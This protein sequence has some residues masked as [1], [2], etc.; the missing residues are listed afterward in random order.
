MKILFI[1]ILCLIAGESTWA[2]QV[3]ICSV[4]S[5]AQFYNANCYSGSCVYVQS[6]D[7]C[8][9]NITMSGVTFK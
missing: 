5:G 1:L 3:S 8:V 6:G 2:S 9:G 7:M 4:N